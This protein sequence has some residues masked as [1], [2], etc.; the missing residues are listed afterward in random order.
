MDEAELKLFQT[1]WW[2]G[3]KSIRTIGR[4]GHS[5]NVNL[6]EKRIGR[7]SAKDATVNKNAI[8]CRLE[9]LGVVVV[10]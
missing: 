6:A 8:S 9:I 4:M 2:I 1:D 7:S 3:W 5:N 10:P